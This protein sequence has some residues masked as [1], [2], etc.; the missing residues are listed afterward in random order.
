MEDFKKWKQDD[1]FE[2]IDENEDEKYI[3]SRWVVTQKDEK[4]KAR[5]VVRGFQEM[6]KSKKKM[7]QR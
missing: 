5:L 6:N 3:T 2:K 4:I 7:H 1:T